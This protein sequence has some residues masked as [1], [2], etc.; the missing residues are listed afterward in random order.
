MRTARLL[1]VCL[2][3]ASGW[4]GGGASRGIGAFLMALWESRPH[5]DREKRVKRLPCPIRQIKNEYHAEKCR[6]TQKY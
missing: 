6:N 1:T 3:G 2:Q 5:V 4:K